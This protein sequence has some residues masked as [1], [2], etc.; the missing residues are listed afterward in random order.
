MTNFTRLTLLLE[1][2]SKQALTLLN[3][4]RFA[5][6]ADGMDIEF[7]FLFAFAVSE[8]RD[9]WSRSGTWNFGGVKFWRCAR[10]LESM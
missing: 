5:M 9:V 8:R 2:E 1:G 3:R 7:R 6:G 4:C 10:R